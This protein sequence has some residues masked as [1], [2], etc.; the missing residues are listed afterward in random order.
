[1]QAADRGHTACVQVLVAAKAALDITGVSD[2]RLLACDKSK[3]TYNSNKAN[4]AN[5]FGD[6]KKSINAKQFLHH[7]LG[8]RGMRTWPCVDATQMVI[9]VG[10]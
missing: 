1:M 5:R 6:P 3:N 9:F 10:I 4:K 8:F 7:L 2:A